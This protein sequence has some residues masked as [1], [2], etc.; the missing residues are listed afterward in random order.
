M[1]AFVAILL[2]LVFAL[3]AGR[4]AGLHAAPDSS[5]CESALDGWQIIPDTTATIPNFVF[6]SRLDVKRV[7]ACDD[8]VYFFFATREWGRYVDFCLVY[9]EP[10]QEQFAKY[11]GTDE[12][13]IQK[14]TQMIL[15]A[16]AR[17]KSLYDSFRRKFEEVLGSRYAGG[18]MISFKNS[19]RHA[20]L[21]MKM[22]EPIR[23]SY[24]KRSVDFSPL[25]DVWVK[26]SRNVPGW[27]V[28]LLLYPR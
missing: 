18:K 13:D 12:P 9:P 23:F 6:E 5:P 1:K 8:G 2:A 4:A 21:K 22:G 24:G 19:R 25:F 17:A 11:Y 26:P 28:F 20:E 7:I 27:V 16:T 14:R 15:A 3:P 10:T